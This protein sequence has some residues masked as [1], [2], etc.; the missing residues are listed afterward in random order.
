MCN[1]N[2]V[3]VYSWSQLSENIGTEWSPDE[4]DNCYYYCILSVRIADLS[5]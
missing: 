2:N 3:K 1:M 4:M 5:G